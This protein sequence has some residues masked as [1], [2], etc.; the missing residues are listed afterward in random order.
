VYVVPT[1]VCTQASGSI[2]ARVCCARHPVQ[3]PGAISSGGLQLGQD[4]LPREVVAVG[5]ARMFWVK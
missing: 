1:L 2:V 5:S 3:W 4:V